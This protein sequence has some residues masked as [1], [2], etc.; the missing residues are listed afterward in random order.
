MPAPLVGGALWAIGALLG[1]LASKLFDFVFKFVAVKLAWRI[2]VGTSFVLAASAVTL[3]MALAVKALI[4]GARI[5]MPASL[6]A[7]TYFLPSNINII[8]GLY[9]SARLIVFVWQWTLRN[10]E[11]FMATSI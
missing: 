10:M 4:I 9:I 6:G 11:R 3:T 5:A 8:I 1:A 7:S 2:T